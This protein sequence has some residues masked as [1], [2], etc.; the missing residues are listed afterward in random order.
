MPDGIN[1]TVILVIFTVVVIIYNHHLIL[2]VY[3]IFSVLRSGT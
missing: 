2:N 3:K 1:I